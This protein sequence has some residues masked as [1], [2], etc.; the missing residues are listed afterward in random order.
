[1]PPRFP[2]VSGFVLAGGKSARMGSDKALL[3]L[4]GVPMLL[5]TARL[6]EPL[7]CAVT[8]IGP[9]ERYAALWAP[10][11]PDEVSSQGPLGAVA[12]ALHASST[13]WNLI[14][15]CDMPY[16]SQPWLEYLLGRAIGSQADAVMPVTTDDA[17]RPRPEP[18]CAVYHRQ[19]WAAVRAALER[20]VRKV[21]DGLRGCS[22]ECIE[23]AEW[24]PFDSHGR[25]FKNMN[26]P[27]DYAEAVAWFRQV[28][29]P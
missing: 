25:L 24:K 2:T 17:G 16:L 28:P 14:V 19:C 11:I 12:T 18:L 1:M 20:G 29:M 8:V 6:L 4:A 5:R 22:V 13:D 9:P 23:S 27:E 21:T 10:V 7:V 26:S 3:E 15:G